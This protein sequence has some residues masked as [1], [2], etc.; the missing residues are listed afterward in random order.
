MSS[1][2]PRPCTNPDLVPMLLG[3]VR[4]LTWYW[5]LDLH[6]SYAV[7]G[8]RQRL[9]RRAHAVTP[10]LPGAALQHIDRLG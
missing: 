9:H 8:R 10:E 2:V 4:P 7:L 1:Y 3:P 5:V 6:R